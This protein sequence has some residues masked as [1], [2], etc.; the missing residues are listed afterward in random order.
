M[1]SD[2]TIGNNNNTPAGNNLYKRFV[3]RTGEMETNVCY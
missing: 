3:I 1:Q 2:E